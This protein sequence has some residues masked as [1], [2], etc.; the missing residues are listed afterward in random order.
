MKNRFITEE[1]LTKER[2]PKEI[3]DFYNAK[4]YEISKQEDG[5]STLRMKKGNC[6]KL[7]EELRPLRDLA[8]LKYSDRNDIKL[9][10]IIGEQ[11]YD[12]LITDYRYSPP[13]KSKLEITLAHEGEQEHLRTLHLEEHGYAPLPLTGT[14]KK[15]GTKNKNEGKRTETVSNRVGSYQKEINRLKKLIGEA[16]KKKS[17]KKYESNTSLLVFCGTVYIESNW[18][19]K[20]KKDIKNFIKSEVEILKPQFKQLYFI[21][22][23]SSKFIFLEF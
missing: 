5:T 20:M 14:I 11:N 1:E 13:S 7:I 9:Q 3:I 23:D 12:A 2:T 19:N 18:K 4:I 8:E 15:K 10:L 17:Q 6:K 22:K 21:L 16:F